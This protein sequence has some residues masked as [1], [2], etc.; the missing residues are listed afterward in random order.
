MNL[1]NL[2][3]I[4]KLN[5]V[6]SNDEIIIENDFYEKDNINNDYSSPN[7]YKESKPIDKSNKS[8]Y[9]EISVNPLQ[10]KNLKVINNSKINKNNVQIQINNLNKF[11]NNIIKINELPLI[12]YSS[13]QLRKIKQIDTILNQKIVNISE[14][15]SIAWKGLP[16][17]KIIII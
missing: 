8:K 2:K 13:S 14:L 6:N 12:N 15:R 11:A 3:N 17:G 1:K 16:Y 10:T 5:N 7:I 9:I 4:G